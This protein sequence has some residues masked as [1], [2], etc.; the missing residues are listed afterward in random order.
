VAQL[1]S[2]KEIDVQELDW[3][4]LVDRNLHTGGREWKVTAAGSS[5]GFLL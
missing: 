3:A 1:E 5:G 4:V 2:V